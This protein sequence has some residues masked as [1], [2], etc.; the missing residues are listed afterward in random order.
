MTLRQAQMDRLISA[1]RGVFRP[2]EIPPWGNAGTVGAALLTTAGNVYTGICIDLPCSIGFCAEHAAVAEM[3]K[4]GEREL[5]RWLPWGRRES[6]HPA[7][8]AESW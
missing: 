7:V 8:V 1:A 3:L 6:C 4:H 2:I 5:R